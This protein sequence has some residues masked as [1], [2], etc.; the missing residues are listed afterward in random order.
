[1]FGFKK[2]KTPTDISNEILQR[3]YGVL[4]F[5]RDNNDGIVP[6]SLIDS[7]YVIGFHMSLIAT[8]YAE[9]SGDIDFKCTED[10]GLV[11]V[12]VFSAVLG[13]NYDE[14]VSRIFPVLQNRSSECNRGVND[15]KNTYKMIQNNN[16]EAFVKFNNNIQHLYNSK[17]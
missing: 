13:L 7:E 2:K 1:M 12:D 16:D 14:L 4:A 17:D 6:D 10:W 5:P 8:L 11:Q 3:V 15:A 9:L